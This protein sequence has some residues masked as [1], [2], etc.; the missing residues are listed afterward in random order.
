MVEEGVRVV[1]VGHSMGGLVGAEC[2]LGL[3]GEMGSLKPGGEKTV[4]GEGEKEVRMGKEDARRRM[5]REGTPGTTEAG[6]LPREPHMFPYV[7]GLLAFDTPYLGISP[8]VVAHGAEE[9][10]NTG[11]VWY[12]SAA[13]VYAAVQGMRGVGSMTGEEQQHAKTEKAGANGTLWQG[14]MVDPIS[15]S[16]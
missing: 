6:K 9:H 1:I 11:K 8:G 15:N 5:E 10:W 12:D 3:V 14:T 16:F 13:G 7:Q 4:A 2:L